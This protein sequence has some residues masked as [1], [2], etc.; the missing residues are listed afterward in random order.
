MKCIL[1]HVSGEVR[2]LNDYEAAKLVRYGWTYVPKGQWKVA[3]KRKR[4]ER[5]P[6]TSPIP[7]LSA[8]NGITRRV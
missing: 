5:L 7:P 1:N 2:R 4:L 8:S 6:P 3:N